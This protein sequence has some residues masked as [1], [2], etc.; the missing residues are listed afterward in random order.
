MFA[1][2]ADIVEGSALTIPLDLGSPLRLL[3]IFSAGAREQIRTRALRALV[4][5][6]GTRAAHFIVRR[7]FFVIFPGKRVYTTNALRAPTA[8]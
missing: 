5:A 3:A 1:H 8:K 6:P 7:F 2:A 4:F